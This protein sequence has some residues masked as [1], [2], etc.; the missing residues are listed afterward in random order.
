[1]LGL[2]KRKF[3]RIVVKDKRDKKF[4]LVRKKSSKNSKY[5]DDSHW[6]GDQK[7]AS[8]CVG[9]AWAHW[10]NCAPFRQYLDPTGIYKLAQYQ[11]SWKGEAYDGTSVRAGAQVLSALGFLKSYQWTWDVD[12]LVSTL[13][14][15]GPVVVGTNW[16][17]GMSSPKDGLLRITG[18]SQG[19]HA[20]L[21]T[22]VNR[23]KGLIRMK[24]SWNKSWGIKGRALITFDDMAKL[25]DEEG[26]CCIGVEAEAKV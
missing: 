25:L 11:D 18:A 22:G 6:F 26:E 5:W 7:T 12:T 8:S 9:H 17:A 21:L 20:Y 2:K 24:N 23:S 1:M 19:G 4:M 10:L 14:E 15:V 16:Y 13:L 3:G